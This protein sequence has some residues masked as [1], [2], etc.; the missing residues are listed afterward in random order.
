MVE[1]PSFGSRDNACEGALAWVMCIWIS[2][3]EE[4]EVEMVAWVQ[5]ERQ[6]ILNKM[7]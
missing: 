2:D 1:G 6:G 3:G 7:N 4:L 5:L